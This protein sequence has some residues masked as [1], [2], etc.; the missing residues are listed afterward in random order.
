MFLIG[1]SRGISNIASLSPLNK[2]DVLEGIPRAGKKIIISDLD[3]VPH[4]WEIE[5]AHLAASIS[6]KR[7]SCFFPVCRTSPHAPLGL[8]CVLHIFR[9][10]ENNENKRAFNEQAEIVN[11]K[12]LSVIE[13]RREVS[14]S[15]IIWL[16]SWFQE[17]KNF[18]L[19][20]FCVF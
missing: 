16:K 3:W 13:P 6:E 4:P 17:S 8:E 11:R 7:G 20:K 9:S 12:T 10:S 14:F 15:V 19:R 18:I 2:N 1:P 5:L